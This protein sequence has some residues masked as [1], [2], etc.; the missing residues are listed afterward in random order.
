MN[1]FAYF[2]YSI[3]NSKNSEKNFASKKQLN[4]LKESIPQGM[5]NST[6]SYKY[7]LLGCSLGSTHKLKL[8]RLR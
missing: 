8:E 7:Y 6:T 1:I 5:S 4:K 3:Y 2:W